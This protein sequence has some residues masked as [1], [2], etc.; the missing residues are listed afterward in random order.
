VITKYNNSYYYA[1]A[2]LDLGTAIEMEIKK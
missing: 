2:V 1:A